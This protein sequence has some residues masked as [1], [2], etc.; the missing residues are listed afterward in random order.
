MGKIEGNPIKIKKIYD[1]S[2]D[3]NLSNN[4]SLG[5]QMIKKK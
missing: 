2:K 4:K 5:N 1:N 3:N